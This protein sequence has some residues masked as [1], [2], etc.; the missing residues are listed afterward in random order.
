MDTGSHKCRQI[1]M[2]HHTTLPIAYNT[3]SS[4]SSLCRDLDAGS[5]NPHS[6]CILVQGT[7]ILRRK[8][9]LHFSVSQIRQ[10]KLLFVL[11]S[12][13][14]SFRLFIAHVTFGVQL[15]GD[16]LQDHVDEKHVGFFLRGRG[17]REQQLRQRPV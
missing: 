2:H 17:Y 16:I 3:Q 13:S 5:C 10:S 11:R 15:P 6:Y 9:V 1:Q 12:S 14:G 8:N 7:N 4:I